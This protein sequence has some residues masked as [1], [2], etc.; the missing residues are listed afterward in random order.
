MAFDFEK[1]TLNTTASDEESAFRARVRHIQT[2]SYMQVG[3]YCGRLFCCVVG[4]RYVV[5]MNGNRRIYVQISDR[6]SRA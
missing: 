6:F 1:T 4:D 2:Q 3:H 5:E